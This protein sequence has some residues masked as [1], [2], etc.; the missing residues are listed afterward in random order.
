MPAPEPEP[1]SLPS[2]VQIGPGSGGLTVAR[3]RG[4]AGSADVYLH[5]AHVAAW[6][7]ADRAPVLWM[8]AASRFVSGE[9]LRGGVPICFPW[10]GAH[11]SDPAA[12]A[13]GFARRVDWDLAEAHETGDDVVLTLRLADTGATRSSAWPH[14][15]EARYTVT[16]G[17]RLTLSLQ[18]TNLD[19]GAVVFEEAF[20]TYLRVADIHDTE[21]TGLQGAGF[22]DRLA[23][24][25]P[26]PGETGPVRFGAETDRIY[27]GTGATATVVDGAAH[28]S[29]AIAKDGSSST[30]VW[31]PW[32]AKSASMADFGDTE[33]T[34]MLCVETCNI[35]DDAVRLE[36]GQSH[37]MSAVLR[38]TD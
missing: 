31:N 26:L 30:V 19:P 15:F 34:G 16:V 18:V 3:V 13:H 6:A 23:G 14:R 38:T 20:H 2:S 25:A 37:T 32:I 11:A 27:L 8:S 7:P 5:G 29:V 21:V 22:L 4:C 17:R 12:P 33:W 10:F 24:P 28:R 36:P 9:P 1:V 35:R